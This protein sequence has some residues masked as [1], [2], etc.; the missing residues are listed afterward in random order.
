M[1]VEELI[2]QLTALQQDAERQLQGQ[3]GNATA[4]TLHK[5]GRITGG[6]KLA[7]GRMVALHNLIRLV[8]DAPA[9]ADPAALVEAERSDW[10]QRRDEARRRTPSSLPWLAYAQGGVD[11]CTDVREILSGSSA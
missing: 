9:E 5:D 10:Q 2:E 7:E 6:L 11:A 1:T 8:R 3:M 4:C